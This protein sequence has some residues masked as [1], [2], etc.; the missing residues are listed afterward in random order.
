LRANMAASQIA[1]CAFATTAYLYAFIAITLYFTFMMPPSLTDHFPDVLVL[2][3]MYRP[4]TVAVQIAPAWAVDCLLMALFCLPHSFFATDATK[5]LMNLPKSFE[6]SFYIMQS[7]ALLHIQ[8]HFWQPF[9]E[10]WVLWNFANDSIAYMVLNVVFASGFFI[11]LF[12]TFCIDHFSLFGL[13]QAFNTDISAALRI[14]TKSTGLTTRGL[15][16]IVAHPI[17]TGVLLGLWAAPTMTASRLLLASFT[18]VYLVAAVKLLEEPRMRAQHGQA[19]STYL[20]SV[21]AFCPFFPV[22]SHNASAKAK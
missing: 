17:M 8:M 6:R 22:S 7:A 15:Y 13:S 2:Y 11:L 16:S 20:Q 12:A 4:A 3:S 19:Y 1:T 5:S 21:P 14:S 18:T 9:G 10:S